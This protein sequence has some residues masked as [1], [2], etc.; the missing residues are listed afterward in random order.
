MMAF[1]NEEWEAKTGLQ[2]LSAHGDITEDKISDL[3][4]AMDMDGLADVVDIVK[5]T[6]KAKPK[7]MVKAVTNQCFYT[8]NCIGKPVPCFVLLNT[9][10]GWVAIAHY[11]VIRGKKVIDPLSVINGKGQPVIY[12]FL[13]A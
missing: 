11:V 5:T 7:D 2:A 9:A 1:D 3:L 4:N 12:G 6:P 10:K 8:A 13:K